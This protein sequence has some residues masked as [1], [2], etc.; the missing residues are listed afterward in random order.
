MFFLCDAVPRILF[1]E[2]IYQQTLHNIHI[3]SFMSFRVFFAH[4][5]PWKFSRWRWSLLC[6]K[7]CLKWCFSNFF[8]RGLPQDTEQYRVKPEPTPR[9]IQVYETRHFSYG[10][11]DGTRCFLRRW[12][13]LKCIKEILYCCGIDRS[14]LMNYVLQWDF[15]SDF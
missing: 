11:Q 12:Y 14:S 6:D 7:F 2:L 13:L 8:I 5:F 1:H 10:T 9:Y 3:R 15:N 4:K